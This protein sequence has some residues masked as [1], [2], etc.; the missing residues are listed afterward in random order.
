MRI[1][2]RV[3]GEDEFNRVKDAGQ[4]AF[5]GIYNTWHGGMQYAVLETEVT[6]G[7]TSSWEAVDVVG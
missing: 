4:P 5:F 6:V 2:L 1:R 7:T 3:L